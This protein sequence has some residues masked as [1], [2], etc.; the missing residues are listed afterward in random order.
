MPEGAFVLTTLGVAI[1]TPTVREVRVGLIK[2]TFEEVTDQLS[3]TTC[4]LCH[5][6]PAHSSILVPGILAIPEQLRLFP[7]AVVVKLITG[8]VL[9]LF[10]ATNTEIIAQPVIF[11]KDI[12]ILVTPI[13][14][15]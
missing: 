8:I 7:V 3:V 1:L 13:K 12:L 9:P 10:S 14:V 15:R 2:L 6:A 4:F 5:L 11:V